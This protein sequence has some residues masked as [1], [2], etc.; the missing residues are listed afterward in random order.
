ME[1]SNNVQVTLMYL[2]IYYVLDTINKN[3]F[4]KK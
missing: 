4:N 3:L 1:L 2:G